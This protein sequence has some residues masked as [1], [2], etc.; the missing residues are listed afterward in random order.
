MTFTSKPSRVQAES[1]LFRSSDVPT[2]PLH[3]IVADLKNRRRW[4]SARRS[5]ARVPTC[6]AKCWDRS[7][8]AGFELSNPDIGIFVLFDPKGARMFRP[9]RHLATNVTVGS[10]D[11]SHQHRRRTSKVWR[12]CGGSRPGQVPEFACLW[13]CGAWFAIGGLCRL[14][15]ATG[16]LNLRRIQTRTQGPH[17][18]RNGLLQAEARRP[19]LDP[20]QGV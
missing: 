13:R 1:S 19:H 15:L 17:H 16:W 18:G 6:A 2:I 11:G 12:S 20:R 8:V 3:H 10:E 5:S 7:G 4:K 9:S 14:E